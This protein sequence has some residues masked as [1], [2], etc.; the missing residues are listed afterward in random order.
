[1]RISDWSSDVCSSDLETDRAL[2]L[3]GISH[4]LRTP[5]AR[6]RLEIELS[7]VSEASRDAIDE[8]VSQIDRTIGQFMEYARPPSTQDQNSN[9]SEF[10][11]AACRERVCPAV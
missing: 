11:R 1:M 7:G 6:L 3:A 8:D 5:L 4:D 2:M 10:G 9:I